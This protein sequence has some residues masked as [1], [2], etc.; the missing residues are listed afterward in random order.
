MAFETWYTICLMCGIQISSLPDDAEMQ[1]V[2][3]FMYIG[4][5]SRSTQNIASRIKSIIEQYDPNAKVYL[6]GSRATG[7][8][9][10]ESD[11]D[12]LILLSSDFV[13][14]EMERK[15]TSPLYDLEFDTG[16]VISPSVYTQK[17]WSKKHRVTP[18]YNN[19]MR[20]G[21]LL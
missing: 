1:T 11:W 19:V 10:H 15:V 21:I 2:F 6:Y 20:E 17:E 16:E 4:D 14:T 3:S 7:K 12:V 8:V 18:F 13:T 9:H 5:M